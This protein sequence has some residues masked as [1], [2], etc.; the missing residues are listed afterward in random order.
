M[1]GRSKLNIV[2]GHQVHSIS[3][4]FRSINSPDNPIESSASQLVTLLY[5]LDI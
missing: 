5:F 1:G 3:S 4:T 2:L